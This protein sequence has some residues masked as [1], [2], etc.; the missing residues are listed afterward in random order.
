MD[1]LKLDM[2]LL[3]MRANRERDEE[4]LKALVALGRVYNMKVT[5]EGVETEDQLEFV[6]SIGCD[7]VQGYYYSKP[8][9]AYDFQDFI[10]SGGSMKVA[11]EKI[12]SAAYKQPKYITFNIEDS[13]AKK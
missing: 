10:N 5:Q 8:L 4:L 3:K 1:E 12:T 9:L 7:V 2:S 6:K 13:E 11:R